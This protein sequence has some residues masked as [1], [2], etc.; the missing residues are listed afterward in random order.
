M[1]N[2]FRLIIVSAIFITLT[3]SN[4]ASSVHF[5]PINRG[6]LV[7]FRII[8]PGLY[9]AINKYINSTN[10]SIPLKLE[11][12]DDFRVYSFDKERDSLRFDWQNDTIIIREYFSYD[13]SFSIKSWSKSD[14]I[15][16]DGFGDIRHIR[17]RYRRKDCSYYNL[18]KNWEKGAFIEYFSLPDG[19][20]MHDGYTSDF[21]RIILKNGSVISI[22]SLHITFPK[23]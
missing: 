5:M 6:E 22:D 19:Q 1:K 2:F 11:T 14:T 9:N 7:D 23:W 3:S 21:Y 4:L 20:G 18:L 17:N 15:F 13:G 8:Q 16:A 12:F 10:C